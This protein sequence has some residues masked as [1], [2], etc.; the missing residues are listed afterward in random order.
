[1]PHP[2]NGNSIIRRLQGYK[3]CSVPIQY[4]LQSRYIFN[5]PVGV[6]SLWARV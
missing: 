3:G 5:V 4:L 6:K 1:M 2:E